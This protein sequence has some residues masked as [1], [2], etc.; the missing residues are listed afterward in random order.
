[1]K[2]NL[3]NRAIAAFQGLVDRL[4]QAGSCIAFAEKALNKQSSMLI[5]VAK[6]ERDILSLY[7]EG[8]KAAQDDDDARYFLSKIREMDK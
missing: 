8:Y 2:Y 3:V 4:F 6:I 7:I 1:M 5:E